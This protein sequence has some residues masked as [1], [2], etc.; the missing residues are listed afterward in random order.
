VSGRFRLAAL[1]P[2]DYPAVGDWVAIEARVVERSGTIQVVL[3]RRTAIARTAGD[4]NR[5]GGGRASDEQVLAANVDVAVLVAAIDRPPNLARLERYLALAWGSGARPVIVLSKAD[6]SPDVETAVAAVEGVAPLVDV[7]PVSGTTGAGVAALWPHLAA[8][9][10]AIVLGP[11]GVGKTTLMN[12]LLG[13]EHFATAAV[14]ASDGRG[15]HTTT[16]RE[17]VP[18][19]GGALL[20]DT[21]GIRSLELLGDEG[22]AATY[23]EIEAIADGCRFADCSHQA[24]PGCA[25]RLAITDGRIDSRRWAGY[26]KLRREAAHLARQSDRALREAERRRWKTISKSVGAHMRRK[27][28]E[29]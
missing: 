14:R 22:L 16:H 28:G 3:P 29:G 23:G 11:S 13:E 20:I 6:A 5:R 12:A 15:R 4:S 10:T 18:L 25:V 19:P 7:L 9:Q 2:G 24:E 8:D 21:P 1:G 27:Y 17:L 26:E